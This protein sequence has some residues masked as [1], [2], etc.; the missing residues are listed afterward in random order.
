[1]RTNR[2]E[3]EKERDEI[4]EKLRQWEGEKDILGD[5]QKDIKGEEIVRERKEEGEREEAIVRCLKNSPFIL[6][7]EHFSLFFYQCPLYPAFP[8]QKWHYKEESTI[9]IMKVQVREGGGGRGQ[10][11]GSKNGHYLLIA[12][13]FQGSSHLTHLLLSLSL[14]FFFLCLSHLFFYDALTFSLSLPLM[15]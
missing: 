4:E 1:M 7:A 8:Y 15:P 6:M 12:C 3:R 14:S 5:R 11:A 9:I 10:G 13:Y 2:R